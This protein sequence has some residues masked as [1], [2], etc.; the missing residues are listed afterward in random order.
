MKASWGQ[1]IPLL[2]LRADA[3]AGTIILHKLS[4]QHVANIG[5]L[6]KMLF[7]FIHIADTHVYKII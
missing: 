2:T 5:L 3:T 7:T 6:S 1:A 4:P